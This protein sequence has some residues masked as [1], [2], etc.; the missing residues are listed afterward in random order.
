VDHHPGI[1]VVLGL[2][3]LHGEL[4][5]FGKRPRRFERLS[6]VLL[7]RLSFLEQL[8][9]CFELVP[10]L[11]DAVC[12]LESLLV[13]ADLAKDPLGFFLPRPEV[14]RVAPLP[15]LVERAPRGV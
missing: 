7:G 10:K 11:L 3:H 12:R 1:L 13:S 14:R 5:L 4:Q 2:P 9:Q 6:R 8:D 15:E